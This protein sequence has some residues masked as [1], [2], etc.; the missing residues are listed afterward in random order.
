[1]FDRYSY[2]CSWIGIVSEIISTKHMS[3]MWPSD[4][5]FFLGGTFDLTWW[6]NLQWRYASVPWCTWNEH[7]SWICDSSLGWPL[8]WNSKFCGWHNV[9]LPNIFASMFL[10]I[11]AFSMWLFHTIIQLSTYL[12][13]RLQIAF[14]TNIDTN[15]FVFVSFWAGDT[16]G[17]TPFNVKTPKSCLPRSHKRPDTISGW[18]KPRALPMSTRCCCSTG[19]STKGE[20]VDWV[21]VVES[22]R[23]GWELLML[24]EKPMGE[25][26]RYWSTRNIYP[27]DLQ[28]L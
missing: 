21:A 13:N 22:T 16:L 11:D 26:R 12:W 8:L 24:E 14:L 6:I 18:A 7:G 23:L 4:F 19:S 27:W 1:M 15:Y 17:W 5:M 20:E 3:Y 10:L 25:F 9:T 2:H 28:I